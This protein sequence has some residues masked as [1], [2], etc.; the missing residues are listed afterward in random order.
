MSGCVCVCVGGGLFEFFKRTHIDIFT[1]VDTFLRL[2][3]IIDVSIIDDG[4]DDDDDD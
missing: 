2:I 3:I 1:I 4:H